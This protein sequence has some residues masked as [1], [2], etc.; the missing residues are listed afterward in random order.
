M[1]IDLGLARISKLLKHLN[2][3]HI[4]AFK[5]IHIAGTNGKGS[6]IAYLSSILTQSRIPNGRF[7]SPHMLYYNDCISINNEIYPWDKFKKVNDFILEQNSLLQLGCTEFE[8]LTVTAFKIF[9]LEKIDIAIIEVGLGGRLDAT[10]VLEPYSETSKGGVIASGIT[11]IGFDH[12]NLLGHTL[13]AIAFE[14]AGIIKAGIPCVVDRSNNKEVIQVIQEKAQQQSSDIYLVDGINES[15]PPPTLSDFKLSTA[16]EVLKSSPLRGDYQLQNLSISLKII[17]LL[18]ITNHINLTLEQIKEG[19]KHTSWPG[20]LQQITI[21]TLNNLSILLDGAHN[22]SAAIELGKFL[23]IERHNNN[24]NNN[25]N[26]SGIIFIIAMT[27]G[28]NIKSILSHI[29]DK[30]KDTIIVTAFSQPDQMPWIQSYDIKYLQ[31]EASLY[32]NDVDPLIETNISNV[33]K[34]VATNYRH[35]NDTRPIVLCGSLYLCGDVL[36]YIEAATS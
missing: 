36:R 26:N 32:V 5:S 28:K 25:N 35:K 8:L 12:E 11:K 9:E 14:K 20:R 17:E 6:T 4:N 33:L 10:N 21:P 2:N 15:S 27:S 34:H 30:E 31:H 29:V 18:T 19:I 1:P 13:S 7:T 23:D 22:E 24:N 3:P 16:K